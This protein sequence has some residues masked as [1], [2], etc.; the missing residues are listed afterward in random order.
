MADSLYSTFDLIR[1]LKSTF[2]AGTIL[3]IKQIKFLL[4]TSFDIS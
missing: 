3:A 4:N 2:K 1:E